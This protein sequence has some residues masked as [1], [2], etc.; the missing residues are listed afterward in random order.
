MFL[1]IFTEEHQNSLSSASIS[2]V[3]V[4]ITCHKTFGS[5]RIRITSLEAVK[6][7]L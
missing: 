7:N 6:Q 1:N 4:A 3:G 5:F 2:L